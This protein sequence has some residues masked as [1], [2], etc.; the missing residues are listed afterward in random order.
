MADKSI[1]HGKDMCYSPKQDKIRNDDTIHYPNH[2]ESQLLRRLMSE[3]GLTDEEIHTHSKYRKMLSEAQKEGN[4]AKRET[5]TKFY[6]DLIKKACQVTGLVPQH[7]NTLLTL[8]LLIDQ[9]FSSY[10]RRWALSV[11][12]PLNA[13]TAVKYYSKNKI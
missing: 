11:R 8:Q 9:T 13:K 12:R 6:Q 5:I 4:V 2:N 3:T 7:P 10:S 1:Y